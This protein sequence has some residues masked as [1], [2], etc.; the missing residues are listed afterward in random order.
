[1][2]MLENVSSDLNAIKLL[3]VFAYATAP[4]MVTIIA[5][6][7]FDRFTEVER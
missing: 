1:M 5:L 3:P 6:R 7:I 4:I 2:C